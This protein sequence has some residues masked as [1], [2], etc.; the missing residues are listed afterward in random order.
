M[1]IE[2][3]N[4]LWPSTAAAATSGAISGATLGAIGRLLAGARK[5][6]E[7]LKAG[8]AGALASGALSGGSTYLG[9]KLLGAPEEGDPSGYTTR[10]MAGGILGGGVLGGGLGYL[11]GSGK[12]G[13][14]ARTSALAAKAEELIPDN[15]IFEWLRKQAKNPSLAKTAAAT[16]TLGGIGAGTAG[17]LG[18]SE[19]MQLDY[20]KDQIDAKR[21][22][23]AQAGY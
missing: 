19:G 16:A 22:E 18:S 9:G 10:G 11:M 13:K 14:L 1:K 2:K 20:L 15:L 7:L 21:R 12:F 17:Y 6:S 23:R 4:D 8:T 5:P 3:N